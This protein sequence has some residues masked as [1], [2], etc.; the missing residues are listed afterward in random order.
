M[1]GRINYTLMIDNSEQRYKDLLEAIRPFFPDNPEQA[2]VIVTEEIGPIF[3][4][5]LLQLLWRQL[6]FEDSPKFIKTVP[7]EVFVQRFNMN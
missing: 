7:Y 1:Y 4:N 2:Y 5:V 6:A 3:N